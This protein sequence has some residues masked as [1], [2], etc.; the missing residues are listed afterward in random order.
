M[1][2]H[3][4]VALLILDGWG[5]GKKDHSDAIFNAKTPIFDGL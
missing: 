4:K 2:N 3:K 1:D 5:Y